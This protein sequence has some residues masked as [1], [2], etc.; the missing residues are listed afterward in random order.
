MR[1]VVLSGVAITLSLFVVSPVAAQDA[2]TARGEAF[3]RDH[4]AQCHAVGSARASPMRA[5]PR[6]RSLAWHFPVDDLA[7]VRIEGLDRRHPAMPT[8][9]VS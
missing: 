7:D 8:R 9:N 1:R 4:G 5:P 2:S 6:F 3:A